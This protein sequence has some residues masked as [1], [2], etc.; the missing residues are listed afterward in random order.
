MCKN[1][2]KNTLFAI[3]VI[4]LFGWT[5]CST[6]GK[7]V[8]DP[9]SRDFYEKARLI[10]NKVEKDIFNHLPDQASRREFIDDFWAKRDPDLETE[11]N[12]F[13][14]EFYRRIEYANQHFKEGPPGWKTDRGRIFIYLGPPDRFEEQ[15][16]LN[17]PDI[18][19]ILIWLYYNEVAFR[20]I[21]ERGDGRYMLDPYSGIYGDFFGAIERA[22]FGLITRG[23]DFGLKFV[24]FE[25]EFDKDKQEIVVSMSLK[26]LLFKEEE[27]LFKVDFEFTFFVYD[28][29]HQN[30]DKFQETRHFEMPEEDVLELEE[31]FFTFRYEL[32]PGNYYID[33]IIKGKPGMTKTRKIFKIKA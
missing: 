14:E 33:V 6:S 1:T 32:A 24:D 19:G 28:R 25:V 27:G 29:T 13:K 18:K 7:V 11:E 3:L 4:F 2:F 26:N 31:L 12:E 9:S 10:M 16:M 8:L 22:Q 15:P 23:D 30:N 5:G 21:D 17:L 20:F